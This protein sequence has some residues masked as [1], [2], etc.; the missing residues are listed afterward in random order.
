MR[1]NQGPFWSVVLEEMS[2]YEQ[3]WT[4]D[5]QEMAIA[6]NLWSV[7][8]KCDKIFVWELSS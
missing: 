6:H 5:R 2:K 3:L 8:I 7:E 1:T 4:D